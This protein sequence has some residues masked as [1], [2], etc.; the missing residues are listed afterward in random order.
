MRAA[1]A[2]EGGFE[3]KTI[4]RVASPMPSFTII[5]SKAS[6]VG[7]NVGGALAPTVPTIFSVTLNG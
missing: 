7:R 4:T 5:S 6:G 1:T 3:I 2:G